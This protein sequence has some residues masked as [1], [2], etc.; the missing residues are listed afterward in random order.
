MPTIIRSRRLARGWT[1][2]DLASRVPCTKKHISRI[3]T[4][5]QRPSYQMLHRIAQVLEVA[6]ADLLADYITLVPAPRRRPKDTTRRGAQQ[7]A[8]PVS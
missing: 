2:D 5:R 8:G 4:G 1:Q 7:G 6:D 3:E